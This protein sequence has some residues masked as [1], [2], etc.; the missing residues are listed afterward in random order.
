MLLLLKL[1]LIVVL[2]ESVSWIG[3]ARI[4]SVVSLMSLLI[5][6]ERLTLLDFQANYLR[7]SV[8]PSALHK[9]QKA[10]RKQIL[11]SKAELTS[12]SSQD[13]F[14]KWAKL[15]RKVDKEVADLESISA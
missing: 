14:A 6:L 12:T 13:E 7:S 9:K 2:T 15:R 3:K 4:A 8:A 5:I 10:M 1:A 11:A